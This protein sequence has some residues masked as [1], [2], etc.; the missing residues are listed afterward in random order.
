MGSLSFLF[1]DDFEGNTHISVA[2]KT[3]S[4]VQGCIEQRSVGQCVAVRG[5]VGQRRAG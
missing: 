3:G 4:T 1:L 2:I 5:S